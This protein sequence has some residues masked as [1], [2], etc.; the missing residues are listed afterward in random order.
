[1]GYTQYWQQPAN[2]YT[3][4]S[5]N[6][7]CGMISEIVATAAIEEGR[8]IIA[9]LTAYDIFMRGGVIKDT[10]GGIEEFTGEIFDLDDIND[11]WYP[12]GR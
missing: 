7:L 6:E 8:Q 11:G 9:S 10:A 4:D 1:V 3:Y 5:F 2:A 12:V